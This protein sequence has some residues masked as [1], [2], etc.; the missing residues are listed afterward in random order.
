MLSLTVASGLTISLTMRTLQRFFT[1]LMVLFIL[2]AIVPLPALAASS[3]AIRAYDDAEATTKNYSGQT[4]IK[5]EFG[6]VNLKGANFS[7]ADFRGPGLTAPELA[8]V[9]LQ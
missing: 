2:I 3:A 1:V 7:G 5:A 4:L 8:T 9:T 6:S